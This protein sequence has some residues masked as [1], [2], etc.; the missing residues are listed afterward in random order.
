MGIVTD[1]LISAVAKQVNDHSLVVWYDPE[2]HYAGVAERLVIPSATIA[3]Y[4]GSFFALRREIDHLMAGTEPPRLVVYVPKDPAGTHN[5]LV[6]LEAAGV[7]LKPGQQPPGRNTR[8]SVIAR[9]ALRTLLGDDSA[10][11]IANQADGGKLTLTDLDT[12]AEKGE[13][14]T[15]GVVSLIFGTGNPQDV[16][17]GLLSGVRLDEEV[18]KKEAGAE[19]AMLLGGAFGLELPAAGPLQQVRTRLARHIL[20][21]D[22]L[23][24]MR[25]E[26]PTQLSTAPVA[27]KPTARDACTTLART[28]RLRRDLRDSYVEHANRVEKELGLE[29]LDLE[30]SALGAVE[31]FRDIEHRL[32]EG[33]EA[34]LLEA[35]DE[36]LVDTARARQ[37]SFWSEYLPDVQARWALAATTGQLL[38]EADRVEEELKVSA[39]SAEGI[40]SAYASGKRPWCLLDTNHRHM[41]RLYHNFEFDPSPRHATLKQLISKARHRYMTVGSALADEFMRRYQK[42]KFRLPGVLLQ[43]EVYEK[44]VKPKLGEGKTAYIW[45]DALRF[46][47]GHELAQTLSGDMELTVEPAVATVPTI[48]EIGM[49]ALLPNASESAR[50]LTVGDSKLGLEVG[51]KI[52]RSRDDRVAFLK[53]NAGVKV[54]ETKLESLLPSPK[55]KVEEGIREAD[56]VLVTSQEID[57]LGERDNVPLARRTMDGMLHEIRRALRVLGDL[58]VSN[59]V[60]AADHGYLFGDELDTDMKID[61]PGGKTADLHRRVWVGNGGTADPSYL[62]ARLA[63]FGLGGDLEIAVPLGFACF[64]AKGG[65]SAYFHGGLSPQEMVIPVISVKTTARRAPAADGGVEWKITLGSQKISTRFVSVQIRA[66]ATG[67]FE[68]VPPRVRVE[69]MAKT[70]SISM[71]VSASYGFE[72][73]TG[74][75]Q[76]RSAEG[77]EKAVEPNTVTLAI[78]K[79]TSQKTVTVRLLDAASGAQLARLEG[80]EMAISI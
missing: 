8:L 18:Q 44:R 7:V 11:D 42:A 31:T 32:Q 12:L 19:L 74:D 79:E 27:T 43:T 55:K 46:E 41:E 58:G 34:G 30:S 80:V 63:D 71:P 45:V 59:V 35:S 72:E 17:L 51:G 26:A 60:L 9:N 66:G 6:E 20:T 48:T 78:T 28:W 24:T 29:R 77:D 14:I 37:S 73:A 52:I 70:E 61:A 10:A 5:A 47:M 69:I 1:Y 36:H 23:A 56:L 53:E 64:K 54:Y 62:R 40:L 16:A 50:V 68:L 49:A 33:V 25:G 13:N 22:L 21:T 76:L 75:V 39:K 67:L 3:R 57:D 4:D 2:R 15:K 38:L 65:A